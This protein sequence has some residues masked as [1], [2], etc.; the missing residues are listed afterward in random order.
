MVK[1]RAKV[2]VKLTKKEHILLEKLKVL[3]K[4]LTTVFTPDER[5]IDIYNMGLSYNEET[6]GKNLR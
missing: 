3:N 1:S 5:A 2:K 4:N 6:N